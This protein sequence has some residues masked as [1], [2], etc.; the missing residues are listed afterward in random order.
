[1]LLIVTYNPT[2]YLKGRNY[3]Y[4]VLGI[5]P[6]LFDKRNLRC[7]DWI[8][9]IGLH[10]LCSLLQVVVDHDY[11]RRREDVSFSCSNHVIATVNGF[12]GRPTKKH[13]T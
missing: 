13:A 11:K 9:Y 6:W 8:F 2:F 12:Q 1:M 7:V 4:D 10:N 5:V 3:V